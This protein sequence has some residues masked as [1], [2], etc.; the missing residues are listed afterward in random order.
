MEEALGPAA[1]LCLNKQM[2]HSM[3]MD[4]VRADTRFFFAGKTRCAL[5][6]LAPA[7]ASPLRST[8]VSKLSPPNADDPEDP[9][10]GV[11][12]YYDA[13][14]V[15]KKAEGAW[16]RKMW[17]RLGAAPDETQCF[18]S[19]REAATCL[20]SMFAHSVRFNMLQVRRE[21]RHALRENLTFTGALT[22]SH[23]AAPEFGLWAAIPK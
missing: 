9:K 13:L 20:D 7:L 12:G 11:S 10:T 2:I 3:L 15:D 23:C 5:G 21:S 6:P 4:I 18:A 19:S 17:E 1:G 22:R 14:G 16:L 8:P